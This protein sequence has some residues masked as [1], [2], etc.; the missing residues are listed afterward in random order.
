MAEGFTP[1]TPTCAEGVD[2]RPEGTELSP[3]LLLSADEAMLRLAPDE[4]DGEWPVGFDVLTSPTEVTPLW[5]S[6]PVLPPAPSFRAEVGRVWAAF[7]SSVAGCS[8]PPTPIDAGVSAPTVDE[9]ISAPW[10]ASRQEHQDQDPMRP[11]S[12]ERAFRR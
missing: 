10:G 6:A 2:V 1:E 7:A 12:D 9:T 3:A 8:T 11:Q 4:L 5:P